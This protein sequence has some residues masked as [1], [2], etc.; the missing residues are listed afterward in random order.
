MANRATDRLADDHLGQSVKDGGA[1]LTIGASAQTLAS[2]LSEGTYRISGTADFWM[3]VGN[4][5]VAAAAG[6]AGNAFMAA[7]AID[8]VTIDGDSDQYV[9]V[10][11]HNGSSG[12]AALTKQRQR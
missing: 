7:G 9:S 8:T 6:T 1:V 5:M 11:G 10:I 3:K 2:A 4:S 12:T